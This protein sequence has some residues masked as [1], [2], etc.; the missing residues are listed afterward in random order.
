MAEFSDEGVPYKEGT[1]PFGVVHHMGETI[2]SVPYPEVLRSYGPN[3]ALRVGGFA[4]CVKNKFSGKVL[5]LAKGKTCWVN[6]SATNRRRK[7]NRPIPIHSVNEYI[8]NLTTKE[9]YRLAFHGPV[10]ASLRQV[11]VRSAAP[12]R[13]NVKCGFLNTHVGFVNTKYGFYKYQMR[14]L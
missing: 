2:T 8:Q 14:V 4:A 3:P 13:L 7:I 12:P 10:S 11:Y 9:W 1:T 5:E 6:N